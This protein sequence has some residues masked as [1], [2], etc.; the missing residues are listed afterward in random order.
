MKIPQLPIVLC[1]LLLATLQIPSAAGQDYQ[2]APDLGPLDIPLDQ[3]LDLYVRDGFVYYHALQVDRAKLD[4]Y[5]TSLG[6]APV[7]AELPKWDTPKQIAFWINAYNAL[8]LQTAV[9]H[10]PGSVRLVPGAFTQVKHNVAGRSVTLDQIE[11]AIL[12]GFNDPRIYLVLGRG[13]MDS[14]RLR[15]EAFSGPRLES[16]LAQSA[17]QFATTPKFVRVD[18]L[19]GT[20][21]VSPI[22]SWRDKAFVEAYAEK[23]MDLPG[24]TPL[25]RAIVGFIQPYLLPAER[26]FLKKNT[27]KLAYLDFDWKLNDRTGSPH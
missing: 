20:L 7:A 3:L 18:P 27:F 22:L 13:A 15:S 5:V 16:Q 2:P 21:S 14:G 12:A 17:E 9:T 19:G 24:R 1:V 25:E 23:S 10:Y 6:S 8:V 11:N 26:D 4:R